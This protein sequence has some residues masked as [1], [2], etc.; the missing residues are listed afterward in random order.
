MTKEEI[1]LV[2]CDPHHSSNIMR[3]PFRI[4]ANKKVY[5][6]GWVKEINVR[7]SWIC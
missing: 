3:A 7:D 4:F 1:V 5:E 6:F 2:L